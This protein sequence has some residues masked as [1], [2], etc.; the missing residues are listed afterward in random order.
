MQG[1]HLGL[2]A[3]LETGFLD[4]RRGE[5]GVLPIGNHPAHDVAAED[6]EQDIEVDGRPAFGVTGDERRELPA[7]AEP[8]TTP[9]TV[10][11]TP[12]LSPWAHRPSHARAAASRAE[13]A[14]PRA[15]VPPVD[16]R[17]KLQ[18]S[19]WDTFAPPRR[20]IFTPPLT[21]AR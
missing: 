11:I 20:Y 8:V 5:R 17:D 21:A 12:R 18:P 19:P 14:S 16:Y 7:Q 3:L 15:R 2:D 4:Q 9:A 10:R 13:G 1:E 6:V